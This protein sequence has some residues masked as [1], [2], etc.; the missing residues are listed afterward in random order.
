MVIASGV[1]HTIRS[2]LDC[3]SSGRVGLTTSSPSRRPIRTAPTG[4]RKG[5]GESISAA[6]APLMASRSCPFTMSVENVVMISCTS[7]L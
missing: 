3:F 6:E 2:R 4:P 1:P 5:I 7:F